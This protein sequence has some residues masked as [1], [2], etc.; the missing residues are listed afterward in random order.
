M[1]WCVVSWCLCGSLCC[2]MSVVDCAGVVVCVW[3]CCCRCCCELLLVLLFVLL[4][5]LLLLLSWLHGV[6]CRGV[7][8]CCVLKYV[9]LAG[10]LCT[11]RWPGALANVCFDVLVSWCL[12]GSFANMGAHQKHNSRNAYPLKCHG[13]SGVAQWLACWA[14]NPKVRGSK[15]CSAML[16]QAHNREPF[17]SSKR[18]P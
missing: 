12:A 13:Q 5:V 4:V 15:P 8:L 7:L 18:L 14:H 11:F 16:R 1:S 2:S 3:C 10:L 9:W 17:C 6:L